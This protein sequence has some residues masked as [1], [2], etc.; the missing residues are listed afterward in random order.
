M[1]RWGV[2][3]H[4]VG[5]EG[6]VAAFER[7]VR[8]ARAAEDAG[9]DSFWVAQHRFGAQGGHLPSPLMLLAALSRETRRIRLGTA[10]I[11]AA[12]EDPR[13]LAEDAAVV[14]A[15]SGGRLELGLGS[16]SDPLAS[17]AW[18]L[19]HEMRHRDLWPVV[20]ALSAMVEGGA[21]DGAD[22]PAL[23][24]PATTLASRMWITAGR[25][26]SADAASRRGLGLI[27][28][29]RRV[30]P[31]GPRAED[32][33]VA[34]MIGRYRAAG[35]ERVA[36]SRPLVATSDL[37]TARRVRR[38]ERRIR[39]PGGASSIAVGSA[40]IL[41]RGLADDPGVR[42]ADHVLVHTRPIEVPLGVEIDSLRLLA[43]VRD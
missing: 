20:D 40:D 17:V 39:G 6:P 22:G 38:E 25:A 10:S 31:E 3:T 43:P 34:R 26:E 14:D 37:S 7:A 18:G 30:G 4:V 23:H 32:E 27:A 29:R 8:L 9:Y 21:V 33:R 15:M 28:G 12:L 1:T 11:A 36:V 2:L 42:L 16:G 24:P 35:G 5:R 41:L 19:D 13:R